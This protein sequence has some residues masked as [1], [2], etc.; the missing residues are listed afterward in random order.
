VVIVEQLDRWG[1]ARVLALD[2]SNRS[3]SPGPAS[4]SEA[5][6][7]A[8]QE[9]QPHQRVSVSPSLPLDPQLGRY[10]MLGTSGCRMCLVHLSFL[11][12]LGEYPLSSCSGAVSSSVNIS[13]HAPQIKESQLCRAI[14]FE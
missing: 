4:V 1:M 10:D 2:V 3:F 6:L 13:H 5:E 7:H 11:T 14:E 12:F 8:S 9:V